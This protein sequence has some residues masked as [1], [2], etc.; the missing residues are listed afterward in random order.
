MSYWP[1]V[2][3]LNFLEHLFYVSLPPQD[4][5]TSY[6]NRRRRKEWRRGV[7]GGGRR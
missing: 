4:Y 7:E 3:I 6:I 1:N 2:Q 5:L